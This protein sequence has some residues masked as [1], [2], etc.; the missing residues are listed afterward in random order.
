MSFGIP[1]PLRAAARASLFLLLALSGA[2][3][4]RPAPTQ[5][6]PP[7][8]DKVT[9]RE[10][11]TEGFV[12]PG[13]GLTRPILENARAMVLAGK[14]PWLSGY[15]AL[16]L[17]GP[18]ARDAKAGNRNPSNPSLP[19]SDAFVDDNRMKG[20]FRGD[21][22]KAYN[23]ALMYYF[24]GDPVYRDNALAILRLWSK[25]DP[26]KFKYNGD[27]HIHTGYELRAMT[28]AAELLRSMVDESG[29]SCWTAED[30]EAFSKNLVRP[31][32]L[33]FMNSN[34]WFM[35]Q[36]DYALIGAMAGFIFMD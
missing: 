29:A 34:G 23:Q 32:I 28:T 10:T 13:I 2:L 35:N 7:V 6:V 11:V 9:I 1:R 3:P 26:S 20:M 21:A 31:A 30:T 8:T 19:Q 18:S 4:C 12:H 15:R 5:T 36:N 24:T 16:A 25:I 14:E 27:A 33:N 22:M 17:A